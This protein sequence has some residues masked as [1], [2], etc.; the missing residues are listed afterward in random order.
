MTA[1]VTTILLWG[2]KVWWLIA[3]IPATQEAEIERISVQGQSEEK[4][5]KTL[6]QQT[7]QV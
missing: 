4:V 3:G 1:N 6:S 7:I 2:K 5:N